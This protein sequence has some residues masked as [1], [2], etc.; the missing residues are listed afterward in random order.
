MTDPTDPSPLPEPAHRL[1]PAARRYWRWSLLAQGAPAVVL[2]LAFSEGAREAGIGAWTPAA[3]VAVALAAAAALV[4]PL[5]W[6]HWRYEVRDEEID[7]RHGLLTVR[8]TL[9]PIRRV[10]HV[11]SASGPLQATFDLATVS[12]HTAAGATR[13]PA[14][15]RA[16]AEAVRRRVGEL[17]RTRDDT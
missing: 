3:A 5:R 12:F 7:L 8:R 9:V 6:R 15:T 17:A 16:E 11:D 14:L 2:A 13:I 4:P 1:P 10:Q